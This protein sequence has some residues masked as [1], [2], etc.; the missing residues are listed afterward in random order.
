MMKTWSG[1]LEKVNGIKLAIN[2]HKY[3]VIYLLVNLKRFIKVP[4]R[5]RTHFSSVYIFKVGK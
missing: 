4:H 2:K 3:E 1:D 5:G